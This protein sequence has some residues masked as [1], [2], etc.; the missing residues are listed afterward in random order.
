[1]RSSRRSVTHPARFAVGAKRS[2]VIA[3]PA[4]NAAENGV[5]PT[6]FE[7]FAAEL[8]YAYIAAA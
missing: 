1:M 4:V 8:A 7:Q 3:F 5:T 2:R 6:E